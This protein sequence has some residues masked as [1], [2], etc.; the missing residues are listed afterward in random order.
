MNQKD[1]FI[2]HAGNDN[3]K[4]VHPLTKAL[5]ALAISY[6]LDEIDLKWGER[7]VEKVSAGLSISKYVLVLLSENFIARN[8]PRIELESALNQ[9]I[10]SGRLTV[11]PILIAPQDVVFRCIPL[12]RD[13]LYLR[14]EEGLDCIAS[15]LLELLDRK[16]EG[17]WVH[18]HPVEYAG[19]VWIRVHK[20]PGSQD[21]NYRYE[22]IW[23][24][25]HYRAD[26]SFG[27]KPSVTLW[28]MKGHDIVPI[29]I[30]FDISPE[31]YVEFGVGEPPDM[32]AIDI[33]KDWTC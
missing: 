2:S 14:W 18:Y 12:L 16:Y 31:C 15:K 9:E 7:I 27:S 5:D 3:Q 11:L 28:H 25:W 20:K 6:W 19:K 22:V 30:Y 21:S 8:W 32:S 24:P 23:G 13:K 29:P 1:V 10:S 4:F 33:N 26:L 17:H